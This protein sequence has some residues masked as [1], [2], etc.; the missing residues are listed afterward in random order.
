LEAAAEPKHLLWSLVFIKVYSTEE[1]HCSIVGWPDPKTF[2]KWSWYFLEKTACLAPEIIN[3]ENRFRKYDGTT[4]CLVSIDCTDCPVFEPWP[5]DPKWYSQKFNGPGLK[6]EVGVCIR[7][8][9]IVWING[10][11]VCSTNDSTVFKEGLANLLAEDEGVECDA[12][13]KGHYSL[14]SKDVSSSRLQRRE[15]N[16]TRARHENINARLK[17]FQVLNVP[18]RHSN[19]REA[20]ME[21]HGLCFKAIAVITQLKAE[22]GEKPFDVTY[23]TAYF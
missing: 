12:G 5:W 18:F 10:P 23:T 19:P 3:L 14:K 17:L 16:K 22:R 9:D 4:T 13:Y 2:R 11:F 15:K 7:T 6:Y 8:A 21:K 20:M 1:V